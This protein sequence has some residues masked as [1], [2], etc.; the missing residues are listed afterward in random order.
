[1]KQNIIDKK[2][3]ANQKL[4]TLIFSMLITIII[5][6]IAAITF[7]MIP[8]DIVWH[9]MDLRLKRWIIHAFFVN[10]PY[11]ILTAL[12]LWCATYLLIDLI[13]NFLQKDK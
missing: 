11:N 8:T 7:R 2:I 5:M 12:I 10:T 3:I 9:E 13:I 6:K 1:M 4:L